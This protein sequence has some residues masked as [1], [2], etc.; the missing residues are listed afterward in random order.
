MAWTYDATELNT[1]TASGRLNSVRL[2]V[3]D[4]QNIDQQVQDE[5]ILFALSQAGDNVY[6]AA[7]FVCSLIAARYARLVTTQLDGALMAEYSDRIKQYGMLA[8]QMKEL[9][10]RYSGRALGISAGGI[11]NTPQFTVGQFEG[12]PHVRSIYP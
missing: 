6:S 8:V 5:E 11:P 2:L 7:S 10:K 9:D 3:G 4:T 12:E 1:T